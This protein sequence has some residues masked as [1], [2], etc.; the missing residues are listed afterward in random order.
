[1]NPI[2]SRRAYIFLFSLLGLVYIRGLFLP[3]IDNDSAHHA[4]IGLR[5]YLTGDYV[6]M[7]DHRGDYIDKPHF[8][9]WI[10]A[11]SYK[12][13]GVTSFAYR[14]PS[15]LFTILGTYSIFRIFT[16]PKQAGWQLSFLPLLS[17]ISSPTA[18][19]GWMRYSLLQSHSPF[20]NSSHS[21]ITKS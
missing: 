5:M 20:G 16:A 7:I 9:F 6:N 3:L 11:L 12:I 1:M 14:F 19:L 21:F 17:V 18:M 2:L 4:V 15:F 10:S 13:F 8:L